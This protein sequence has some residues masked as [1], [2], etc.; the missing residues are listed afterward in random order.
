MEINGKIDI[1][2]K[3][4]FKV[5]FEAYYKP[6][7]VFALNY[8]ENRSACEDTVQDV[9][10]LLWKSNMTF[11]NEKALRSYL[12]K[13][14]KNKCYN[15]LKHE[16]VV[17]KHI[18]NT[19]PLLKDEAIIHLETLTIDTANT[20]YKAIEKLSPRRAEVI[21]FTLKGFKNSEIAN[22]MGITV[23]TVK[24][25]K[26]QAYKALKDIIKSLRIL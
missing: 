13:V 9:F 11:N 18:E 12:Y 14:T 22:N 17:D 24:K 23:G 15:I 4:S 2:N 20:L 26:T 21:R 8:I 1:K 3:N 19:L 7:V 6:L 25:I 16:K 5:I 10:V